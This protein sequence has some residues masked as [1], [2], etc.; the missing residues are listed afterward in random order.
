MV[1]SRPL[2]KTAWLVRWHAQHVGPGLR[3]D[4]ESGAVTAGK[5]LIARFAGGAF[6]WVRPQNS[7]SL[8]QLAQRLVWAGFFETMAQQYLSGLQGQR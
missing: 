2:A 1:H 7:T 8:D 4:G 6:F 3:L 5:I